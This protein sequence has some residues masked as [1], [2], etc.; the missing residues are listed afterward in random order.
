MDAE[1]REIAADL[2]AREAMLLDR[3]DWD[4]WL[5]LY[6][7]DCVFWVPAWRED[8][9]PVEDPDREVS[10]IYHD[11]REG[12][13]ERIL[14]LRTQRS[15]TTMPL[16]RTAHLVT[17]VVARRDGTDRIVADAA[18]SV[19]LFHPR[20]GTQHALFG[21]SEV[22]LA[23]REDTWRI[24]RKKILV[25]NDLIPTAVDFYCL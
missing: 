13:E 20:T 19:F 22:L 2:L 10:H 14:R 8:D 15:V 25:M 6:A 12:L 3:R 21:R 18:F 23:R 16:W 4:G 1:A 5:A 17:G 7:E 11:S 9:T 24:A